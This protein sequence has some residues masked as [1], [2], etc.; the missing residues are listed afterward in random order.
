MGDLVLETS[1]FSSLERD[2]L[3]YHLNKSTFINSLDLRNRYAH[4]SNPNSNGDENAFVQDYLQLLKVMILIVLKI[5]DDLEQRDTER[6]TG[7]NP[8]I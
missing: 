4:G 2:Y 1:L 6:N 7:A 3:N 8:S 5:N